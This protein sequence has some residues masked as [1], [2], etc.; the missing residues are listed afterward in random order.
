VRRDRSGPGGR[1][2]PRES[3]ATCSP[4]HRVHLWTYK[5]PITLERRGANALAGR[6]EHILQRFHL[7]LAALQTIKA[8]AA[9]RGHAQLAEHARTDAWGQRFDKA[10]LATETSARAGG[11]GCV[12]TDVA[13][14]TGSSTH[15]VYQS[16]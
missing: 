3:S 14:S 8:P 2:R 1:A 10:L 6:R 11:P 4:G 7:R 15:P 16:A 9:P 13:R 12:A 5:D